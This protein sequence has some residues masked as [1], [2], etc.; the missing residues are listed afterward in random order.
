MRVAFLA[1]TFVIFISRC[2][3]QSKASVIAKECDYS[4]FKP[5]KIDHFLQAA[6][7]K[8]FRPEYPA[9]GK[10]VRAQGKVRIKI[11]VDRNGTVQK[12]CAI[13]GHSLLQPTFRYG[14]FSSQ[15]AYFL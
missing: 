10:A 15:G 1:T 11:L 13:E 14:F 8:Q 7:I 5:L 3:A 2:L 4:K 9:V 6:L 12:A